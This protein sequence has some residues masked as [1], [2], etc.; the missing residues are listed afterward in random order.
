MHYTPP[1]A[2][3]VMLDPD[4]VD[5]LLSLRAENDGSYTAS[6]TSMI[7]RMATGELIADYDNGNPDGTPTT[8]LRN[9]GH[10]IWWPI[11]VLRSEIA[12]ACLTEAAASAQIILDGARFYGDEKACLMEF[13]EQADHHIHTVIPGII[14]TYDNADN[15][16]T[17]ITA[18][19]WLTANGTLTKVQL[20]HEYRITVDTTDAMLTKLASKIDTR[21][22]ERP[23]FLVLTG[24]F[25]YLNSIRAAL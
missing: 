24:T 19:D 20:S 2:R 16:V 22:L 18:E 17:S 4:D 3:T 5:Y 15:I 11:P 7:L 23:Y 1:R 25:D 9:R 21:A 10:E 13:D 8:I 14:R 6:P 12:N